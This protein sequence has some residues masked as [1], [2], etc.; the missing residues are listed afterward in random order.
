MD[1]RQ[2]AAAAIL[3]LFGLFEKCRNRVL[4]VVEENR[5]WQ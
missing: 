1:L 3:T 5:Q 2:R 4:P